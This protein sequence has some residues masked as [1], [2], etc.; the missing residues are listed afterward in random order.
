M[1]PFLVGTSIVPPGEAADE[2]AD[3]LETGPITSTANPLVGIDRPA[4]MPND[5]SPIRPVEQAESSVDR[6]KRQRPDDFAPPQT[7]VLK[8]RRLSELGGGYA[9]GSNSPMLTQSPQISIDDMMRG[10]FICAK[11]L[12]RRF[13]HLIYISELVSDLPTPQR[14]YILSCRRVK[15]NETP[16]TRRR[17]DA[18]STPDL[19]RSPRKCFFFIIIFL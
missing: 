3:E 12:A 16:E 9:S 8:H 13:Y 15:D 6:L 1:R 17:M 18:I 2:L 10:L 4:N 11:L 7:P 5:V 14:D 19:L